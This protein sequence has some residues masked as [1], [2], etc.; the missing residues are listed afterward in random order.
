MADIAVDLA[1]GLDEHRVVVAVDQDLPDGEPVARG[2]ALGPQGVAGAAEERDVA[3]RSGDL[4]RRVVH[5][6]DHQDLVG[7]VVLHDRR[8]QSVKFREI[9]RP[10]P[11]FRTA[12]SH[13]HGPPYKRKPRSMLRR[14]RVSFENVR[15][16]LVSRSARAVPPSGHDAYGGGYGARGG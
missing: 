8:Y 9:H 15:V 1:L 3:G 12:R 6:A 4:P 11:T 16:V 5:E 14:G 13:A 10:H 2:L 7:Q